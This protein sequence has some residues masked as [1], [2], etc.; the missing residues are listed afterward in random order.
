MELTLH[1]D[2]SSDTET[3][4]RL[5]CDGVHVC[6]TLE[7]P[8]TPVKRPGESAIPAGRY[9]VVISRSQ[10]FGRM[11]PELRNVPGF[12]GVRMH[13]GN[14]SADTAGCILVGQSR[15]QH[16]VLQSALALGELQPRLARALARGERVWLTIH[17]AGTVPPAEREAF[18][19]D[20]G[21]PV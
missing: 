13:A 21:R 19:Q 2:P 8:V 20:I 16:S 11:L 14:T 10:R 9:E 6:F 15:G 17:D 5:S 4:G 7:D 12:S 3:T 1:R 18:W